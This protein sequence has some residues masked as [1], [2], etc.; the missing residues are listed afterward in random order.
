MTPKT[1]V[2]TSADGREGRPGAVP[3]AA[4]T[5]RGRA[6]R[7]R[8]AGMPPGRRAVVAPAPAL[9]A[10]E[11]APEIVGAIEAQGRHP[12][13]QI[14]LGWLRRRRAES[15]AGNAIKVPP[16]Y[17]SRGAE[18]VAALMRGKASLRRRQRCSRKILPCAAAAQ[19]IPSLRTRPRKQLCLRAEA[20]RKR[21]VHS[22]RL[23]R[24]ILAL[25]LQLTILPAQ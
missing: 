12:A 9:H 23:S 13:E 20:R 17:A 11:A 19:F 16:W 8:A 15:D 3:R 25:T 24:R 4:R 14:S 2:V 1:K 21:S 7:A 18:I 5:R 6:P 22:R 10:D